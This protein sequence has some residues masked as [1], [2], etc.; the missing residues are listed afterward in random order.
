MNVSVEPQ[1]RTAL[2][3][4]EEEVMEMCRMLHAENALFDMSEAKVRGVI[5]MA[6]Y[7]KGGILGVIGAPGH[8]EAMI[9]MLLSQI[10]HSEQWHVEEL[11]SYCRPEYRKSNNAKLLIKFAKRCADELNLPLI[12]GVISN[13][14]TAQ[15]VELYRRQFQKPVGAFFCYNTKWGAT[16]ANSSATAA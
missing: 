10:W 8:I 13:D 11:F 1:V 3:S 16:Q 4:D 7:R 2:P 15:K 12:I 5:E 14:R 9:Y 6:L